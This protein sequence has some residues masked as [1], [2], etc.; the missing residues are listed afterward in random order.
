MSN[1]IGI[2]AIL[3]AR[4]FFSVAKAC[5]CRGGADIGPHIVAGMN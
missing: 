4:V 1:Q 5:F 2:V 3:Y